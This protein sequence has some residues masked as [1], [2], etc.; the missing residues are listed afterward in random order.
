MMKTFK[1]NKQNIQISVF[2]KTGTTF[3]DSLCREHSDMSVGTYTKPDTHY[4]S[5]RY[6]LDRFI[7]GFCTLYYRSHQDNKT[8]EYQELYDRISNMS[9][10]D[11]FYECYYSQKNNWDFDDHTINCY[12]L[13]PEDHTNI[14]FINFRDIGIL[15]S[16]LGYNPININD[17]YFNDNPN[18]DKQYIHNII[19]SDKD[20]YNDIQNYLGQD[21]DIFQKLPIFRF[22]A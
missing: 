6:P 11:A 16:Q 1:I 10:Y 8:P 15:L 20:L 14:V 22:N 2:A 9:L 21:L 19:H 5:V 18:K 3:M 17:V 4:I 13:I 12:S 7:S